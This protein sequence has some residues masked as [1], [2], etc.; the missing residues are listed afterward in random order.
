LELSESDSES[1]VSEASDE[2]AIVA[3]AISGFIFLFT[4]LGAG[5]TF[6]VSSLPGTSESLSSS[7]LEK[8]KEGPFVFAREM[9]LVTLL[10]VVLASDSDSDPEESS[11]DEELASAV[12]TTLVFAVTVVDLISG[13]FLTAPSSSFSLSE[14][15]ESEDEA[16]VFFVSAFTWEAFDGSSSEEELSEFSSD[17]E[18][19]AWNVFANWC[20]TKKE[21]TPGHWF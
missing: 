14:D 20:A 12:D 13:N 19:L 9:A 11:G 7:S 15:E 18:S 17:D 4:A 21:C 16:A 1:E 3:A 5:L 10:M 6:I 8:D 2:S